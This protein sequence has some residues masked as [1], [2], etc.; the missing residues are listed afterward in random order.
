M[1]KNMHVTD[2]PKWMYEEPVKVKKNKKT[3]K[4]EIK[5]DERFRNEF[6]YDNQPPIVS[7]L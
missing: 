6:I 1:F 3:K 2:K 4:A 7:I 5:M